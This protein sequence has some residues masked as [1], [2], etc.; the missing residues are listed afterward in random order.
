MLATSKPESSIAWEALKS[1]Y[2]VKRSVLLISFRSRYFSGVK[3]LISQAI[4]V[5]NSEASN[6]LIN[7]ALLFPWMALFQKSV[8]SFPNGLTVPIPV[9]TTLF[10]Y[11]CVCFLSKYL[12]YHGRPIGFILISISKGALITVSSSMMGILQLKCHFLNRRIISQYSHFNAK[13]IFW[14]INW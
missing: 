8:T 7:P 5:L 3:S 4:C 9:I 12:R 13:V 10:I 11:S 6:L 2:W 14:L 1:A